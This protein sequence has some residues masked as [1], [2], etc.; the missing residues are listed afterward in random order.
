MKWILAK[1]RKIDN[2]KCSRDLRKQNPSHITGETVDW[3]SYSGE[4]FS[5][6]HYDPEILLL[7]KK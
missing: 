4:H 6:V 1:I 5:T 7:F 2:V 3:H